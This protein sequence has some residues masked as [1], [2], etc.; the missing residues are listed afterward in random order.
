M[1]L[2]VKGK[3]ALI[4][5]S[6]SGLGE[7][8]AIMLAA[9]GVEVIVHG[10]DEERTKSVTDKINESGGKAEYVIGDLSTDEGADGIVNTALANGQVDILI[11]N[12]GV[13]H[14]QPWME[15]TSK[16]WLDT[17]NI[18][19]VSGIRMAQRL[20]PQMRKLGWGRVVQ[21]GST[22]A[23]QPIAIQPDYNAAMAARHNITVSLARDLKG[24]GITSNT[25]AAG[26][27]LVESVKNLILGMAAQNNWGDNWEEIEKHAASQF[28][29]NDIGRFGKPEE[30]AAAVAYLL[31]SYADN[32]TGSILR[33]DGG[34]T[35]SV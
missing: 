2:R 11:N 28:L 12:A 19:V 1:D 32:V 9:E 13:Y 5:G 20:L 34:Q 22:A 21:I 23:M 33:V 16:E 6:S 24:S 31:S 25:V 7:A 18:N 15:V 17:Y 35:L 3:R 14:G 27:M 4:T 30:V 26:P 8:I 10:R 29:Q